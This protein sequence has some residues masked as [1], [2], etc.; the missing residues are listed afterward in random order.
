MNRT[1]VLLVAGMLITGAANSLLNK[2]QDN[3]CIRN[4]NGTPGERVYF[5]QPVFQTAQMFV[6]EMCCWFIYYLTKKLGSSSSAYQ[7][8]ATDQED[9]GSSQPQPRLVGKKVWLLSLPSICDIIATTLMNLGLLF[10]PVSIF[11]MTRGALVLFAGLF[12]VVFLR[13]R[14]SL[15][16]W[17][18]LGSVVL[19]VFLV[20]LSANFHAKNETDADDTISDVPIR[21]PLQVSA[22]IFMIL[23]GQVF[24]A[25]QFVFEEYILGKYSL[26]PIKVVSWEGS[27]GTS[28]TIGGS[29]IIYLIVNLFSVGGDDPTVRE[30]FNLGAAANEVFKNPN[31]VIAGVFVMLSIASFNFFGLSVTRCLSA[32]SRSTIDT[33]RT[34]LIW[35]V[36]L[37][38][39]WESFQLLQ[40]V[41]FGF[42]VYGTLIFNG[43]VHN[44]QH[45]DPPEVIVEDHT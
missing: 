18:G 29:I 42:L 27:F 15:K 45:K 38:L 23:F 20:G 3:Q 4:C 34:L 28:I 11:Q 39:G 19:G 10:V 9:E 17:L 31:L 8:V 36:S 2:F 21:S 6:A 12:S 35:F 30:M 5:E 16:E 24:A 1:I 7:P 40:L 26:A 41:G 37:L 22:G 44:P 14:I 43:V 25:S 13:H 33:C 32:T